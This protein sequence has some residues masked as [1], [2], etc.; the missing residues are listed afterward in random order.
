MSKPM[1][2]GDTITNLEKVVDNVQPMSE[3]ELFE[4][5]DGLLEKGFIAVVVRSDGEIA[6][7]TTPAGQAAYAHTKSLELLN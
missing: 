1:H 7:Q 2:Q 4:T 5:L 3:A 6:F